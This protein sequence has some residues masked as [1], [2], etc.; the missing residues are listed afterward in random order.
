MGLHVGLQV[1]Q[2]AFASELGCVR[3]CG[4]GGKHEMVR[5]GLRMGRQA[6]LCA[7]MRVGQQAGLRAVGAACGLAGGAASI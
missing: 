7:V 4:W 6:E 1:G 3:D 2:Q 5:V